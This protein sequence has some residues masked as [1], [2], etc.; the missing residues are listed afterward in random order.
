METFITRMIIKEA[1]ISIE[2]GQ[3]KYRAYFIKTSL[4]KEWKNEVD[5]NLKNKGYSKVIVNE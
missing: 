2:K 4:Y 5:D 3:G 1:K